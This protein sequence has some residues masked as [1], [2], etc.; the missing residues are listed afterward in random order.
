[1]LES[2]VILLGSYHLQQQEMDPYLKWAVGLHAGNGK[3]DQL[4]AHI[5][6]LCPQQNISAVLYVGPDR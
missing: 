1:M 5:H 6:C 3:S 4:D 2:Q